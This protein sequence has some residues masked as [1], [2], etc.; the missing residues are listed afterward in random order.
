M[1]SII[2]KSILRMIK[3]FKPNVLSFLVC[4]VLL[5]IGCDAPTATAL[6]APQMGGVGVHATTPADRDPDRDT[7][8][9][10]YNGAAAAACGAT[11]TPLP[12]PDGTPIVAEAG[13]IINL[14]HND[15]NQTLQTVAVGDDSLAV[16]WA[17]AGE[18]WYATAHGGSSLKPTRFTTGQQIA[19][20][21]S[22]VDRLHIAW[23]QAGRI[24]YVAADDGDTVIDMPSEVGIGRKPHLFIDDNGWTHIVYTDNFGR[25]Q[26]QRDA[27]N[28]NWE[29][30]A[31]PPPLGFWEGENLTLIAIPDDLTTIPV[32]GAVFA[33]LQNGNTVITYRLDKPRSVFPQ[34]QQVGSWTISLTDQF[35]G[36]VQLDAARTETGEITVTTTWVT[37]PLALPTPFLELRQPRYLAVNPYAP[38][39]VANGEYIHDGLNA[40]GWET[41]EYAHDAGLMQTFPTTVGAVVQVSGWAKAWSSIDYNSQTNPAN[42]QMQIGLDPT[43][44]RNPNAATVVWSTSHSPTTDWEE[45]SLQIPATGSQMTIFLRSRPNAA[46]ARSTAYFDDIRL[47]SGTLANHSFEDPFSSMPSD[48]DS[49]LPIQWEPFW[50]ENTNNAPPRQPYNGYAVISTDNGNSWSAPQKITSNSLPAQGI[51]GALEDGVHPHILPLGQGVSLLSIY[52]H[53]DPA[54]AD[55]RRFGRIYTTTCNLSLTECTDP[56][57]NPLLPRT[58]LRPVSQLMTTRDPFDDTRTLAV[59]QMVQTDHERYDVLGTW[60]GME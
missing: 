1:T 37:K 50:E 42:M 59:W 21:Y 49:Q 6:C 5:Q 3:P 33:S 8:A 40:V 2:L 11:M 7:V 15:A 25:I 56:P 51:T 16:G 13:D 52:G 39:G 60:I 57:G 44:G 31:G 24:Y 32:D 27:G 34:W 23:E 18:L 43:A 45:I 38:N 28:R 55:E 19:L 20:A 14:D 53:G 47:T 10:L 36:R 12:T 58:A 29:G 48:P 30:V 22:N 4:A 46:R 35:S 9:A 26:H 17:Q 41:T 54:N